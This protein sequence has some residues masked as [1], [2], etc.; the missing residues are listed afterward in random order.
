[1][2]T[3][4]RWI[5]SLLFVLV[6]R[7]CSAQSVPIIKYPELQNLLAKSSDSAIVISFWAT[8]CKPCVAE[9]SYFDHLSTQYTTQKVKVLLI[10]LDGISQL[11]K[12]VRPFLVKKGI[13]SAK[14]LLFDEANDPS[15]ISKVAPDWSG[16]L[17]FTI[18][19]SPHQKQRKT[20]ERSFS[21]LEL[22][23]ELRPFIQ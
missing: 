13:K 19:I 12:R 8:W 21:L 7:T 6:G 5:L 9:L 23:A 16:A 1:M 14:V 2:I 11:Q 4:H 20:F 17:P 22:E 15:W 18:M 3:F 10:N